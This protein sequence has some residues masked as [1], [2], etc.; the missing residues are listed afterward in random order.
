[1]SEPERL[2]RLE[3]RYAHLQRHSVEQDKAM[4]TLTE[5]VERLRRELGLLRTRV[6]ETA[7]EIPDAP[8]VPPP[9]Y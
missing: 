3:E 8:D 6:A 7:A 5:E 4:L 1:M 9:H 2:L